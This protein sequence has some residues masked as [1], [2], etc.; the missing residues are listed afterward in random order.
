[1]GIQKMMENLKE[2]NVDDYNRRERQAAVLKFEPV[3]LN[4]ELWNKEN[5]VTIAPSKAIV[6]HINKTDIL[7]QY[8]EKG[9]LEGFGSFS[10]GAASQKG[11]SRE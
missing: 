5:S 6:S 10:C 2:E 7:R 1:M 11:Y 3:L 9:V 4:P 8:T